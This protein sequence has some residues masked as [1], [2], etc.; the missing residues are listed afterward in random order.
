MT[1]PIKAVRKIVRYA[2]IN[3]QAFQHLEAIAACLPLH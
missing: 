2:G 3:V 1:K